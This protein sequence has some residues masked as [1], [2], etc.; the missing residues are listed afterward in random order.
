MGRREDGWTERKK[1]RKKRGKK[2]RKKEIVGLHLSPL[3][4]FSNNLTICVHF[5]FLVSHIKTGYIPL[6]V[7]FSAN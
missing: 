4:I 5:S 2:E 7:N 3:N 1:K 6:N